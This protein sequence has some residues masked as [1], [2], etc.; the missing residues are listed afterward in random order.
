[1]Q[2][3]RL[4]YKAQRYLIYLLSTFSGR[5]MFLVDLK[6]KNQSDQFYVTITKKKNVGHPEELVVHEYRVY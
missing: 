1:M 2:R 6:K 3:K 4:A 5:G